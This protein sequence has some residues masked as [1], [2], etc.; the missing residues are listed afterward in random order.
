MADFCKQCSE[1]LFGE[2]SED[3]AWRGG[4]DR[5]LFRDEKGWEVLCEGCG[6]TFVDH[7]GKC[8]NPDCLKKHGKKDE[9]R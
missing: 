9:R 5:K 1:E 2:D 8:V 7:T 6:F 3:L 4:K